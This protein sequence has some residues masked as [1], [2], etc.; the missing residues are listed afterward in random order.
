MIQLYSDAFAYTTDTDTSTNTIT[1]ITLQEEQRFQQQK[2][3]L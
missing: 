2:I 3:F 1:E